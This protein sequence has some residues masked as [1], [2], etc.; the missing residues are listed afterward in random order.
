MKRR[1]H[2]HS[3]DNFISRSYSTKNSGAF[4]TRRWPD[5]TCQKFTHILWNH[6]NS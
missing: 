5:Y 3:W 6:C 4:S 2:S 1:P